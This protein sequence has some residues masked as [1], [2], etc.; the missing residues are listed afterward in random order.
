MF[1]NENWLDVSLGRN[2]VLEVGSLVTKES[3][4][5]HGVNFAM[6]D[7]LN[8]TGMIDAEGSS[9]SCSWHDPPFAGIIPADD[10]ISGCF[11]TVAELELERRHLLL[12]LFKTLLR[13]ILV[14]CI[15]TRASSRA[16]KSS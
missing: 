7:V 11:A 4:S 10:D 6:P 12:I 2:V 14:A 13:L 9:A 15:F 8:E 5:V 16:A 3:S 1:G